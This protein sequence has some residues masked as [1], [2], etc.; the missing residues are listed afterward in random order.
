MHKKLIILLLLV[1]G[2]NFYSN[3]LIACNK[4]HKSSNATTFLKLTKTKSKSD[5]CKSHNKNSGHDCSKKCNHHNCACNSICLNNYICKK[6]SGIDT[7]VF[8]FTTQ[9]QYNVFKP[10]FYSDVYI[11]IW[12]PPKI[13]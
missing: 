8:Y 6:E 3:S 1:I 12:H 11:S 13:A 2:V 4:P 10:T 5:C 9:M 7:T